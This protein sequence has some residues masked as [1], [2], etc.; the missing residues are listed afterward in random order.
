MYEVESK[1]HITCHFEKNVTSDLRLYSAYTYFYTFS[2][3]HSHTLEMYMFKNP[4]E[5]KQQYLVDKS[6]ES[7]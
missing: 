4:F 3:E 1:W 5:R 7:F 6:V 2:P